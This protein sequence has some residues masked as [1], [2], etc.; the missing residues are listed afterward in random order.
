MAEILYTFGQ[1]ED[2]IPFNQY[3]SIAS[4]SNYVAAQEAVNLSI[5]SDV[6]R[7]FKYIQVVNGGTSVSAIIDQY[8]KIYKNSNRYKRLFTVP[9]V[10]A[11]VPTENKFPTVINCLPLFADMVK[12]PKKGQW[13]YIMGIPKSMLGMN[14]EE[15][16]IWYYIPNSYF[17]K[18]ESDF[19]QI[20]PSNQDTG[21]NAQNILWPREGSTI[22]INDNGTSYIQLDNN[23]ILLSSGY[24]DI[25]P[26][27]KSVI[28]TKYNEFKRFN[29]AG[30][31]DAFI[32]ISK[33]NRIWE[34]LLFS[35]LKSLYEIQDN[36]R[37]NAYVDKLIKAKSFEERLKIIF[38]I[39]FSGRPA[40]E[41]AQSPEEKDIDND[42]DSGV[43][44]IGKNI[45]M[46]NANSKV[47]Y[48]AARGDRVLDLLAGIVKHLEDVNKLVKSHKHLG[49]PASVLTPDPPTVSTIAQLD[50][51]LAQIKKKLES[52][53]SP[54]IFIS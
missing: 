47:R 37:I 45:Y 3:T 7:G 43:A 13:I 1:V 34:D 51:S 29:P 16:Y 31:L 8:T 22:F 53:L 36:E 14:Q 15:G 52:V 33:Y 42:K 5:T 11:S 25:A 2:V 41:Y 10:I 30:Q 23:D 18:T 40:Y 4:F 28:D 20:T 19:F 54:N 38:N 6:E 48:H 12:S 39:D 17:Y 26:L 9:V 50:S 27:N 46:G 44:I 49:T 21:Q 24:I 32:F 35:Y